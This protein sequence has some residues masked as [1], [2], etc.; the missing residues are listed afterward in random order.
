MIQSVK[1]YQNLL[2][3][4]QFLFKKR[5]EVNKKSYFFWW[6]MRK[7]SIFF[8]LCSLVLRIRFSMKCALIFDATRQ[9]ANIWHSNYLWNKKYNLFFNFFI[10][11]TIANIC[12]GCLPFPR[13]L[14]NFM[15]FV[16]VTQIWHESNMT[17][18]S[19]YFWQRNYLQ[20]VSR[21]I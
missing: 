5:I 2:K 15:Q 8:L 17:V 7:S 4:I 20:D 6:K 12:L 11:T 21:S 9:T 16:S 1:S 3:H 18:F 14:E 13:H 10:S 19:T